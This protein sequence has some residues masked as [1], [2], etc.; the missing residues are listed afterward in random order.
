MCFLCL[1]SRSNG[2]YVFLK[3]KKTFRPSKSCGVGVLIIFLVVMRC[4]FYFVAVLRYSEPPMSPST[5]NSH[6]LPPTFSLIVIGSCYYSNVA[7][8]M[9]DRKAL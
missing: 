5:L 4:L 3:K 1:K 7:S 2:N 9:L 6:W 8:L